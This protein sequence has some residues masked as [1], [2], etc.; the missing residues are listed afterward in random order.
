[1]DH[2]YIYTGRAQPFSPISGNCN[3]CNLEK[4]YIMIGR[5]QPFS[6]I[7]G[8]CNLCNLEKY[9]IMFKPNMAT[10]NKKEEINN[11]CPHKEKM[12]LDKT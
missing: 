9:Y 3:L 6:P 11:W 12:L 7:S 8:N 10:L 4:Y 1:M 5:A 2:I